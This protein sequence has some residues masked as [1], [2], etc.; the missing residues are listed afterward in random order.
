MEEDEG[1]KE[2]YATRQINPNEIILKE[3]ANIFAMN[4]G[5]IYQR[6]TFCLSSCNKDLIPCD[7]CTKAMFCSE[8]CKEKACKDFHEYDCQIIDAILAYKRSELFILTKIIWTAVRGFK[9]ERPKAKFDEWM[10]YFFTTDYYR[11]YNL[12]TDYPNVTK[13]QIYRSIL[14]LTNT[15][16]LE[17]SVLKDCIT[18]AYIAYRLALEIEPLMDK[19]EENREAMLFQTLMHHSFSRAVYNFPLFDA[20][21]SDTALVANPIGQAMFPIG[22][23]IKQSNSP[24]LR[25]TTRG[26]TL[27]AFAVKP[28][29]KDQQLLANYG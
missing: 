4:I 2:M 28:I 7:H 6:C 14:G 5:E 23:L 25:Q 27:V 21:Q 3:E 19:V 13:K 12:N 16:V 9:I 8:E 1:F 29:A 24:N 15:E 17:H 11:I 18:L 20:E 26:K 22:H 10:M